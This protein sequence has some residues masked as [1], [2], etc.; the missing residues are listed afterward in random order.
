VYVVDFGI[1]K[2]L[3]DTGDD[4]L[5]STGIAIGTPAYMSPEQASAGAVDARTAQYS[6]ACVLYEMLCGEP[7]FTGPTAAAIIARRFAD[8]PRSVRTVRPTT[9]VAVERATLRAL[10]RVPADRFSSVSEF[11]TALRSTNAAESAR[12]PLSRRTSSVAAL[13]VVAACVTGGWFLWRPH[14][15]RGQ[16]SRDAEI[17]ALYQRGLHGYTRRTPDGAREAIAAFSAV[18][19]RDSSYAGAWNGLAKT[20]L[21]AQRRQFA[22]SGITNDAMV[23]LALAASDRAIA[24]DS[25]SSDAWLTRALASRA[26]DPT[27]ERG[28]IQGTQR[29][30]ALDSGNAEAWHQLGVSQLA[31]GEPDQ[32]LTSWRE[33]VRRKPTY[34]EGL[35]F[36]ALA[37][38]WHRQFDSAAHW[39]DS[40]VA[41]DES[42]YLGR[43]TAGYVAI[44]RGGYVKATAEFE[45]ALR[46]S[47]EVEAVNVLAGRAVAEA[48]AGARAKARATLHQADSIG[49][50]Y[51]PVNAH[52]AV[53]LAQGYAAAAQPDSA[54]RW[55]ERYSP[56]EDLH[57][58]TH[59]RCDP[60]FDPIRRDRRFQALLRRPPSLQGTGC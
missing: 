42:F 41:V 57:F 8:A 32:A 7:P 17:V 26:L 28:A 15:F 49:L 44:E 20:Y 10:E 22:L 59:L 5:T 56:V 18:L 46:V 53:Y 55:L 60:P 1:S 43:A 36:L 21:Q 58:Q 31:L 6:L 19:A 30:I 39:A 13:V 23:R 48:R 54:I 50:K 29:A 27:Q 24:I 35:S 9:P 14:S 45:A 2:A 40:A 37:H 38:Y 3:I 16:S 47:S 52:T 11:A 4:R 51:T 12:K 25:G 33:S 34:T